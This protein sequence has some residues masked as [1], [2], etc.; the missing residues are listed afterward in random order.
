M[1]SV[2]VL[3]ADDSRTIRQ[4]LVALL[5]EQPGIEVVGEASDGLE[6]V[7]LAKSL[8][9]DVITMD[10]LMPVL[11]GIGAIAA[12]MAE[13]P[14]RILVVSSVAEDREMD[15]SF[16]AISVGAL[17]IIG[18]PRTSG[19][20]DLR[21]WGEKVAGS[22]R[23]MTEVPVVTR[24]RLSSGVR[25]QPEVKAP[26]DALAV[27][28][29]TGGPPAIAML[30][31]TLPERLPFPVLIAQHITPGFTAGLTRWFQELCAHP[32]EIASDGADALAGHIYLPPDQHDLEVSIGGVLRTAPTRGGHCPSG[33]RLFASLA[34]VYGK[35]GCGVILT[36]MGEDG[37]QGLLAIRQAGGLTAGQ[38][39]SSSVVFGMPHAAYLLGATKD[40]LPLQSIASFIQELCSCSDRK[41]RGAL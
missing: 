22:I 17:E 9:P 27:V 23:L 39:A 11:D 24:W 21:K 8:K 32:V 33:N 3:V 37:A 13:A 12:I 2:R 4:A 15:L 35:R 1:S 5:K 34:R 28:A 19:V 30:L 16:R 14:S 38:D 31:E 41:L 26:I 7:A 10:V 29:S 25:L 20:E 36:G 40:L 6:A 18:K